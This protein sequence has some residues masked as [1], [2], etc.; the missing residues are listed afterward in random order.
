MVARLESDILLYL[1]GSRITDACAELYAEQ[2]SGL[3]PESVQFSLPP[4]PDRGWFVAEPNYVLRPETLESLFVLYR[5]TGE[6]RWQDYGWAIFQAL[7]RHC[8][9]ATAYSGV[10]NV[11]ATPPLSQNDEMPSFA[12]AETFKYL[13]LLFSPRDVL[14]LDTY[15][16]TTE[17]H[18]LRRLARL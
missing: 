8:R 3:A 2:P 16:F 5:T 15:V 10:T 11:A 4:R 12:L 7:R 13:Y 17:G 9:T 1:S 18:P 14:P 6:R